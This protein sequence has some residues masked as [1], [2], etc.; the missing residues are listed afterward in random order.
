MTI[1]KKIVQLSCILSLT[2]IE[3]EMS[4][5]CYDFTCTGK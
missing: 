3:D 5:G 4:V 1:D 2:L